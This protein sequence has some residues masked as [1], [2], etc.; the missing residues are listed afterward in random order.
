[1]DYE[2]NFGKKYAILER[3]N[4]LMYDKKKAEFIQIEF[5]RYS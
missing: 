5:Y 2:I 4:L 1:M 3:F